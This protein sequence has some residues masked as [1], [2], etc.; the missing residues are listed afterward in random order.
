MKIMNVAASNSYN[1]QM[2]NNKVN[3]SN[4]IAFGANVECLDSTLKAL[5]GICENNI[6]DFGYI[7]RFKKYYFERGFEFAKKAVRDI[8][9]R[10]SLAQP[11]QLKFTMHLAKDG[12]G[13]SLYHLYSQPAIEQEPKLIGKFSAAHYDAP[14]TLLEVRDA[15]HNAIWD[16]STWPQRV[17]NILNKA[18]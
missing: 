5:L 1:N 13:K 10:F 14:N 7:S 12:E 4:N 9:G 6:Q 17:W 18:N 16:A 3:K 2:R 8:R 11:E 15:V